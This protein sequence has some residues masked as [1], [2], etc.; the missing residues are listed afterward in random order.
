MEST[1]LTDLRQGFLSLPEIAVTTH[2][3][4]GREE[5]FNRRD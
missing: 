4:S 1:A 3:L 5:P 2:V